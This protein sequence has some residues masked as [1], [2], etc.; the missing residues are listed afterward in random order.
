MHPHVI[1]PYDTRLEYCAFWLWRQNSL[2][3]Y[4]LLLC[5]HSDGRTVVRVREAAVPE[6]RSTNDSR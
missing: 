5:L 3:R 1:N 6:S 4:S 2:L